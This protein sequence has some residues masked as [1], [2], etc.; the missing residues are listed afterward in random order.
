[1]SASIRSSHCSAKNSSNQR[2]KRSSSSPRS[3]GDGGLKFFDARNHN[4]K[5]TLELP[6]L[7]RARLVRLVL[8]QPFVRREQSLLCVSWFADNGPLTTGNF[9]SMRCARRGVRIQRPTR[10][11]GLGLHSSGQPRSPGT[12]RRPGL[13]CTLRERKTL[14]NSGGTGCASCCQVLEGRKP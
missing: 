6:E 5:P 2:E 1:M 10:P 9:P 4:T 3:L 13:G 12:G 11:A 8:L 14:A 7:A